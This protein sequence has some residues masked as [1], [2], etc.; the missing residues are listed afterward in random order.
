MEQLYYYDVPMSNEDKILGLKEFI[1][2]SND[3][4][5]YET[6][7]NYKRRIIKN[8]KEAKRQLRELEN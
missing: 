3:V 5:K 8:I 2:D 1:K 7:K 6:D 4:L